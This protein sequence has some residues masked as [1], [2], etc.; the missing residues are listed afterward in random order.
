MP[1]FYL[2]CPDEMPNGFVVRRLVIP[3]NPDVIR[4]VEWLLSRLTLAETWIDSAAV[5]AVDMASLMSE[6]WVQY[7][8]SPG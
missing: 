3:N 2:D 1:A 8:D 5:S 4:S 7:L 6:C